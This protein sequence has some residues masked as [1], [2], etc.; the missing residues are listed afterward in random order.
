[1]HITFCSIRHNYIENYR[2]T[3]TSLKD[4]GYQVQVDGLASVDDSVGDG[5]AVDDA[6]ENVDENGLHPGKTKYWNGFK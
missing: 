3:L 4:F 5:S 1:M 2:K 6:A